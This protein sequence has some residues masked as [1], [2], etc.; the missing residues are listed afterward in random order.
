M[1]HATTH[2]QSQRPLRHPWHVA[3]NEVTRW[4]MRLLRTTRRELQGQLQALGLTEGYQ[5]KKWGNPI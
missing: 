4:S 5:I 3:R 1:P 2:Y